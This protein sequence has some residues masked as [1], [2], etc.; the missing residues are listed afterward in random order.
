MSV[1]RASMIPEKNSVSTEPS[2]TSSLHSEGSKATDS[3]GDFDDYALDYEAA[4]GRGLSVSGESQDYFAEERVKWLSSRLLERG[5]MEVGKVMDFGCGTGASTPFLLDYL[6]AEH[7]LGVDVS[8]GSLEVARGL[9]A[10]RK[11]DYTLID[12][13]TPPTGQIDLAF[14]NG[15]FHHIPLDQR[16]AAVLYVWKSLKVGGFF[17]FWENNPWNPGTRYVMSRIPFDRDAITLSY[18]EAGKLLTA[19]GFRVRET[20]FLFIFP[21][22]LRRLRPIEKFVSRLPLGAQYLV[23]CEKVGEEV[24]S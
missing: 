3:I 16:E 18:P 1:E 9:Y 22:V 10:G 13:D 7:V 20:D 5:R 14:C 21:N 19:G 12:H 23:L 15:V 4:L 24:R 6:R 8:E 2:E 17:A 11:A